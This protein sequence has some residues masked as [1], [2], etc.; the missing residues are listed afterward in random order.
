MALLAAWGHVGHH[1]EHLWIF[2]L[3]L[4]F[5]FSYFPVLVFICVNLSV[6]GL[7]ISKGNK[8]Q[9]GKTYLVYCIIITCLCQPCL[10]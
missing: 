7:S 2:C 3:S 9:E 5:F 6:K 1:S 4:G 10:I 8:I